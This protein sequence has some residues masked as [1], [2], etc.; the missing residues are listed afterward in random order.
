[1][2]DRQGDKGKRREFRYWCLTLSNLFF[3]FFI[4]PALYGCQHVS[5]WM[6]DHT[7]KWSY[8]MNWQNTTLFYPDG[9]FSKVRYLYCN[10]LCNWIM[11]F[12]FLVSI[13]VSLTLSFQGNKIDAPICVL[14]L[15][16]TTPNRAHTIHYTFTQTFTLTACTR[17]V[18]MIHFPIIW[19]AVIVPFSFPLPIRRYSHGQEERE[20]SFQSCYNQL[21][22][23]E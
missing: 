12:H 10:F 19:N 16:I 7:L 17:A 4:F 11:S 14:A 1:M 6:R 3:F 13:S 20:M 2:R 8:R 9:Q 21:P 15:C 18:E 22:G 5:V 23:R